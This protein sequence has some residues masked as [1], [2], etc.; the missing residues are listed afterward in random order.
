M[1]KLLT[2]TQLRD[3]GAVAFDIFFHQVV[4]Q[5]AAAANHF[6]QTSAGMVVVL[7]NLQVLVEVVDSSGENRDLY[8]WG[9]GVAF[10]GCIV[11][12]NFGFFFLPGPI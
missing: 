11:Y 10:V 1:D 7:V 3:G 12:N 4:E 6:E 2:D 5:I 8:L 9:T